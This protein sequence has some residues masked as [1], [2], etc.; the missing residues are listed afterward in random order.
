MIYL[1]REHELSTDCPV[2]VEVDGT[3]YAVFALRDGVYVTQ[4]ECTHGPGSLSEGA[5]ERDEVICP[6]HM[7]RFDIRT[8]APTGPPC[9][10][11]LRTW[12][13]TV[14]EGA[15]WIDPRETARTSR[16]R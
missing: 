15:V 9:T 13:A 7:G 16:D 5:V 14:E 12:R 3:A 10:I 8:G 2:R 1:C 4:D 6:F 11:A